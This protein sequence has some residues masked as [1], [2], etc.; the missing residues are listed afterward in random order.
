MCE[1][2]AT[3]LVTYL[4]RNEPFE[5]L[6][7]RRREEKIEKYRNIYKNHQINKEIYK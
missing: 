7:E 6:Y 3:C 2:T 5:G 4:I 1:K